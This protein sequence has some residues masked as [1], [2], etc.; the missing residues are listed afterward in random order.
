MAHTQAKFC[1]FGDS[2]ERGK[3]ESCLNTDDELRES[4]LTLLYEIGKILTQSKQALALLD[5][6]LGC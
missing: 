5:H 2:F 1:L 4:V 3:L 6:S